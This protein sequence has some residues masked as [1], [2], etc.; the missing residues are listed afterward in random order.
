MIRCYSNAKAYAR[1]PDVIGIVGS[2]NSDC[3]E[4]EIPVANQAPHGPLAMISPASTKTTLTRLVRGVITPEDLKHQYPTGQ[5]NFV[6]TAAAA[7]LTATAMAQFA[8]QKGVKRLFLS[9]INEDQYWVEYAA[10]VGSAAKSLGIQIAGAAPF[11]PNA[12]NYARFARRIAS[13]R[14]S[15]DCAKNEPK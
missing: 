13:T 11:D 14:A 15:T 9:W 2:Y 7:H 6:R 5:R 10:D 8:K 12:R 3:S 4:Q 1:N